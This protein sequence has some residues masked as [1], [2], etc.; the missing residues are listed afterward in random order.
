MM[1][2]QENIKAVKYVKSANVI[3]MMYLVYV[4]MFCSR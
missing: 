1:D 4:Y 3:S 2:G